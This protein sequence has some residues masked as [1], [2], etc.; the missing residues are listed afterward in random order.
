[1]RY[2]LTTILSLLLLTSSLFGQSYKGEV[3]YRW[4]TPFGIQWKGFGND[5]TQHR[6]EGDVQ[7]GKPHGLGVMKYIDGFKYVGE[8]KDGKPNGGGTG[9]N[10]K[11]DKYVGEWKDGKEHGQGTQT[12]G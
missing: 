10:L 6:Y 3:L 11:G 1:M 9:T 4:E 8:W 7:N 5:E 12:M 2:F